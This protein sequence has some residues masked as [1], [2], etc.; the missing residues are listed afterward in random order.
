MPSTTTRQ[1]DGTIIVSPSN[2]SLQSA[3]IVICH[4]LGDS[5]EGFVDVAEHLASQ[6]PHVKF[7]LP[8]AKTQKV[9]MNMGMAMPSW[10]DIV[11]LDKRSNEF[12]NG[13]E[14]SQQRIEKL[15]KD[16]HE[17]LGVPYNRMVLA[18]FSQGGALSLYTGMQLSSKLAGIVIMSGYL[19]H[20]SGFNIANGLHDT[21]IWHGHGA[22]DPLVRITAANESQSAVKAKG[23]TNYTLKTYPGLAHS[24]N[25][26]E[27]GDVLSFLQ[28]ILPPGGEGEFK[29]KL[30]DPSEMSVKELKGAISKAGLGRLALGLMEK[31]EFVELLQKHRDGKL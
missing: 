27:I 20:E 2:E 18:G 26:Q 16:E 17:H 25:P 1:G 12:C 4:G 30:K 8:T 22:A 31:R 23:A 14:E 15:L 19:P 29:V 24:V 5:S 21:P 28:Q 9:T 10:Y 3:T 7:I 11:G 13:I 6:M